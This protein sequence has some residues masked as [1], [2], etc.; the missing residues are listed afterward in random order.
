MTDNQSSSLE[1][2][3]CAQVTS[4]MGQITWSIHTFGSM[5]R[6]VLTSKSIVV[7]EVW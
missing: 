4:F 3:V 6:Y 5:V 7:F 2:S 1:T